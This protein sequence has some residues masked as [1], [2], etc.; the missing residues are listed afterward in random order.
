MTNRLTPQTNFFTKLKG[1]KDFQEIGEAKHYTKAPADWYVV[2]ADVKNSTEAVTTGKYKAVNI[3]GAATITVVTNAVGS[4][5]IPY[6]FGGD[7]ATLLTPPESIDA[8]LDG[9]AALRANVKKK[10]DLDMHVGATPIQALYN[11]GHKVNVGKFLT[12]KHVTQA[13]FSGDGITLAEE[14]TKQQNPH[15]I[16]P[17]ESTNEA[18]LEGLECRWQPI[19]SRFGNIINLIARVNPKFE[20]EGGKIYKSIYNAIQRIFENAETPISLSQLKLTLNPKQL[21]YEAKARSKSTLGW[22]F[23]VLSILPLML[24]AKLAFKFGLSIGEIDG[25]TYHQQVAQNTDAKKFDEA[26]RMVLDGSKEELDAL[27][28]FLEGL[29]KEGKINYGLHTSKTA[30][31]TCLIFNRDGEHM[32]FIDGGDGGYAKAA[33]YMKNR[34]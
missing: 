17:E 3:A 34:L 20:K 2:V 25:L 10:F 8:V 21:S 12:S 13:L 28:V 26:L 22:V 11:E 19:D 15:S 18:D 30:L 32:H 29:R 16:S 5:D 14:W 6:V 27:E 24:Y 9:L 1:F 23:Y 4:S 31:M 7:G 33:E